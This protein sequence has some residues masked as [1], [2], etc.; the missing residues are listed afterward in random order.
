MEIKDT[1]LQP[2][3]FEDRVELFAGNEIGIISC[4]NLEER[5]TVLSAVEARIV[6][7]EEVGSE[8]GKIVF[9]RSTDKEHILVKDV[10][11]PENMTDVTWYIYRTDFED[12]N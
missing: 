1:N 4:D 10:L 2:V 3:P 8:D 11:N 5:D 6:E 9:Y 12:D 7:L